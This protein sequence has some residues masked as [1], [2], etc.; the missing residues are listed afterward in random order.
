VNAGSPP[1]FESRRADWLGVAEAE[2]RIVAAATPLDEERVPLLD[3]MGCALAED[4][5][6]T[7]TLPPWDNS[8]MDG[9]AARSEDVRG[10]S[11]DAPRTLRVIGL[12]R[13]GEPRAGS[14]GEG[15]AIRI[16][17][18]APL[19]AGCD[20]VVRVE[21]TDG[22]AEAGTVQVYSDRDAG[23]N[24]RPGGEDMKAG[25]RVLQRGA[26]VHVGAV[27]VL[28]A[29]GR[30]HVLV[31]R[32]PRVAILTTGDELRTPDR[33]E[34]VV[35]GAGVP[36]SNGPM[37]AAAVLAAGGD[38][39][40]LGV[41]PDDA[42]A[43]RGALRR[44]RGA[45]VLVTVGGASMGEADLVKRVLDGE[46]FEQEFWRVRMR[47]GSPFG[48]G[49]LPAARPQ[50]VF[51]LPGNPS[52]AFVTFELFVRPFL[53]RLAGHRHVHRP[54]LRCTAGEPLTGAADLEVYLRVTIDQDRTPPTVR[55][56]GP[57]GSGL[58][59]GLA[60]A[61]GLAILPLGVAAIEPGGAVDVILVDGQRAAV[62]EAAS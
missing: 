36:E 15:E 33:Y 22:E 61:G 24:V 13:A 56:T 45:D 27:A 3:S 30:T 12:V 5:V 37:L 16:M 19:P 47:P 44:G 20:S 55:T 41:A 54:R 26:T 28:A 10:A 46:G 49:W 52:S 29:L 6:A 2:R 23:R 60:S 58:V 40:P 62:S 34:D 1:A 38:P 51:S 7:A 57:Q 18:G 25:D 48:F 35:A 59:R 17:T 4:A 39:V 11:R 53:L 9:Y 8:A 43:V 42:D 31:H 32:R 50:P 21:D 14:V